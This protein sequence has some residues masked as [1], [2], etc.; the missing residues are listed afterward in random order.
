[1]VEADVTAYHNENDPKAAATLRELIHQQIIPPGV[2]DERSIKDVRPED[3]RGYTQ[4]HFFA[5]IGIWPAAL[6]RAGWH[7]DRPVWTGS[8]PCQPFSAAG[9][10]LGFLDP[11]HLWPD[12]FALVAECGADTIFGEQAPTAGAWIDLVSSDL[13]GL[14]YAFGAPDIPAAG[15]G[16]AHIRQ[17]L[18]WVAD[19]HDPQRWADMAPRDLGDWPET[20][21]VES[22]RELGTGS[23]V[24]RLA[25][26]RG[27]LEPREG[28]HTDGSSLHFIGRAANEHD[29]LICRDGAWRPV[30]SGTFPLANEDTNRLGRL[31]QYGN[32]LDFETAVNFISAYMEADLGL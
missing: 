25:E 7:P 19:A 24:R 15:F 4:H 14:G 20:G 30:E 22:Y 17:R 5:G 31:R 29:W 18:Y 11:R 3:L 9:K 23:D 16:G 26:F 6:V 12:W 2:V 8:C 28:G 13:E 10:R 1:M 21:R 32:A 27:S